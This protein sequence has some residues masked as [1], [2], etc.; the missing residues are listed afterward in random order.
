[1][2][3]EAVKRGLDVT[4]LNASQTPAW[5]N[6]RTRNGGQN[7]QYYDDMEQDDH[8]EEPR[9]TRR[10]GNRRQEEEHEEV[11]EEHS[12]SEEVNFSYL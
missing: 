12:Q 3:Q 6:L 7:V 11:V 4:K 9:Q 5:R 2:R 1:M 8:V 10:H